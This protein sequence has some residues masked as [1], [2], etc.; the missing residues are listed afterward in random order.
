MSNFIEVT[1]DKYFTLV[2]ALSA[3]KELPYQ[4][5][6]DFE[7]QSLYNK[8]EKA[9]AKK[10][11]KEEELDRET[12]KFCKVVANSSGLSYPSITKITHMSIAWSDKDALVVVIPDMRTEMAILNWIVSS[13]HHF[14]IHNSLFDLKQVYV[15][16]GKLPKKYDDSQLLAKS[17]INHSNIWKANVGLKEL[18]SQYYDPK[19]CGIDGYDDTDLKKESFL[20]YAAIDACATYLLWTQLQEEIEEKK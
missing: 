8:E 11:L 14:I 17:F 19:W 6:L 2:S 5:S 1:Y 4:V 7:T 15:K 10:F 16:T 13:N 3:L 20:K 18:M 12:E 9:E